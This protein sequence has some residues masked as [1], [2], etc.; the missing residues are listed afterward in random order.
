MPT[1]RAS[2]SVLVSLFCGAVAFYYLLTSSAVDIPAYIP[3][4]LSWY[5][6]ATMSTVAT[7][8]GWYKR[9]APHPAPEQW[10]PRR[11]ALTLAVLRST[12]VEPEGFTLALFS[13][14][15]DDKHVAVDSLGRVVLVPKSD[16]DALVAHATDATALPFSQTESPHQSGD[17]VRRQPPLNAHQTIQ[18]QQS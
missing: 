4:S 17:T 9:T 2:T 18:Q 5:T 15:L 1:V 13:D 7:P 11:E 8:K 16:H 3:S 14:K 6:G 12:K 10:T